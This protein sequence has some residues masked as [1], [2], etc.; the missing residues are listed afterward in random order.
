MIGS[1]LSWVWILCIPETYAP[2]LLRAK[3]AKKRKETGDDRWHSRYEDKK[4]FWPFL[5]ENL[6]R[7]L[8][9]SVKEPIW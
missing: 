4:D 7:P 3:A 8:E 9:M 5:K 1:G 6:I 2:A